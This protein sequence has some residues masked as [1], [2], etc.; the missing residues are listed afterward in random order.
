[1]PS[2]DPVHVAVGVI[3]NTNDEVLIALRH[4]DSHQGGLWEFP[5]GKLEPGEDI[6]TA[7]ARE[8]REELNLSLQ[9]AFPLV[10]ITHEYPD[11][12]VLLDVWTV[13]EWTGEAVGQE[14]QEVQWVPLGELHNLEFPA[15]NQPIVKALQLPSEIAITAAA[16]NQ[17]ELLIDIES[18]IAQGVKA[19]QL[20][21]KHLSVVDYKNWYLGAAALC[22]TWE[23]LLFANTEVGLADEL[24]VPALH[25]SSAALLQ[26]ECRPVGEEVVISAACHNLSELQH[27]Q[28]IGLD[29]ALLSPVLPTA[30]YPV[31]HPLLGWEGFQS[32][33]Q[34]VNIPVY[35]LGG[36]QRGDLTQAKLHGA[37][38]IA[39][40]GA[41]CIDQVKSDLS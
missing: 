20:R 29:L 37:H 6:T 14:G 2:T 30:K 18:L 13:T 7:L 8:L 40:I 19:I 15:A 23:V 25:L 38:G 9:K 26:H 16:A 3:L 27:A 4:P 41:F 34:Q 32:L 28:A 24:Q 11:K 33:A 5:G 17:N 35:A 1:M 10:K 22:Q 39:G 36:L 31:E 12:S 21:Q